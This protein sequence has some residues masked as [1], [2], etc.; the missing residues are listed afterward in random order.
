MIRHVNHAKNTQTAVA[1]IREELI[2]GRDAACRV[3]SRS[4]E[5]MWRMCVFLCVYPRNALR[6][7]EKRGTPRPYITMPRPYNVM[8]LRYWR[9]GVL[10]VGW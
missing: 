1:L 9:V 8:P 5:G 4:H 6:R 3:Y 7:P 10:V 2:G